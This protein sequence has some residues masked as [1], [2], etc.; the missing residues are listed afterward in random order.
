[1]AVI[2]HGS[3]AGKT[4]IS[5]LPAQAMRLLAGASLQEVRA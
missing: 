5:T 4:R 1:M 3:A 2:Q